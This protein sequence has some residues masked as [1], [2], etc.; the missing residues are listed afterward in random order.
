MNAGC[1]RM[2]SDQNPAILFYNVSCGTTLDTLITTINKD[3][4]YV[5]YLICPR[6]QEHFVVVNA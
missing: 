3:I 2:G 5:T 1:K 4:P 6:M